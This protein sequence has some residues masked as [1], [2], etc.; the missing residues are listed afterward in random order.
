MNNVAEELAG[1]DIIIVDNS[2]S[3][4]EAIARM[5]NRFYTYG[6]IH[7]FTNPDEALSY[8]MSR[9][10]GIAVF[11]VDVF[12]GGRTGFAFLDEL[13]E[14]YQSIYQDSIITADN[15]TGDLVDMCTKSEV[16]HLLE[17][18]IGKYSLELAIRSIAM[19]YIRF[20]E[21]MQNDP[22]FAKWVNSISRR[23]FAQLPLLKKSENRFRFEGESSAG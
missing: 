9:K 18:P 11:I 21:A 4:C 3:I 6:G 2:K 20:A 5:A 22:E 17:K 1:L 12:L 7:S 14:R 16:Y 23:Y 8:C 13:S 10:Y 19:K 15:A